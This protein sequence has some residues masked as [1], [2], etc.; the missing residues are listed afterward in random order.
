MAATSYTLVKVEQADGVATIRVN[1]PGQLNSVNPAV[2]HQLQQAVDEAIAEPGVR[3]IVLA[4]GEKAFI[5]GA[6]IGFFL[7]NLE[8]GDLDRIVQYTKAGHRLTDTIDASPKPVVAAVAGVALGA[9]TEF[10]LAC[11]RIVASPR[12]SF[13]LPETGLGIYPGF[14]GTQRTPRAVGVGLA[15][16]LIFTGKTLSA[17]EARRVGLVDEVVPHDELETTARR[18]VLENTVGRAPR[19]PAT[20]E[21]A[22]LERFFASHR[23]DDLRLGRAATDANAVLA[24]AMKAVG[25]KAPV[26]LR[27]AEWLIDEGSRRSLAEGLQLEIDRAADIFRTEDA[28]RGLAFCAARQVGHPDFVGR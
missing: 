1:R 17:A 8:A 16:W 9:G 10:A 7:R 27:L 28:R 23:A 18:R 24:R 2:L 20:P 11:D 26:A 15:K 19:E 25:T 6:E 13:G 21:L 4:G 3:G 12:A 14:G 5:V 22:A